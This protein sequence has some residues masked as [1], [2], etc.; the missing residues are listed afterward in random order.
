MMSAT[1]NSTGYG[2]LTGSSGGRWNNLLFNGDERKYETWEVKIMGYMKLKKLKETIGP[3]TTDA[4]NDEKNE[5]AFAELI[6]FLDDRS[7]S[8]VMRD[9]RDNGREALKILRSHYRGKGKQRI[10]CLYTELTTLVKSSTEN[11]T[12]YLL[13]AEKSSSALLNAGETISDGLLVSMVLKGLPPQFKSFV[14]VVTQSDKTWTFKDL[15]ASLRDYED[16][17]KTRV[18]DRSS[19]SVMRT[20]LGGASTAGGGSVGGSGESNSYI[21]FSCN[22]QGHRSFEC[23]TKQT[24][25]RKKWCNICKTNKHDFQ[26]CRKNKQNKGYNSQNQAKQVNEEFHTFNFKVSDGYSNKHGKTSSFLVDSGCSSHIVVDDGAFVECDPNFVPDKHFVELADGRKYNNIALM[27]GTVKI[28]LTDSSGNVHAALLHNCLYIPSFPENI[29]SIKAATK[30]G[31]SIIFTPECSELVTQDGVVFEIH[32][33][34]KL[35]Y[36]CEVTFVSRVLDLKTWHELLGHCNKNDILK[37][38]NIVDGMKIND[39]N[40]KTELICEPCILGKQTKTTD[41]KQT[42]RATRPL[43]FVCSDVC[44]PITPVAIDGFQYVVTFVDTYS[45]F[46]FPYFCKVKSDV[47]K[48]LEKFL[49]DV[50]PV[51]KVK[52]LHDISDVDVK[53]LRSDNGGEYMG[54]EFKQVLVK[55]GIKHEQS[56]PY[57]PHQNGI[58]ERQW[59]TL[60]STVRCLLIGSGLPSKLWTYALMASAYI[61]NRCFQQRIKQTAYFLLTGKKPDFSNLHVFGSVCYSIEQNKKKLDPRSKRGIFVGWDKESPAFL[62]YHADTGRVQRCRCVK[63]TEQLK[64]PVDNSNVPD[65]QNVAIEN[66]EQKHFNFDGDDD[67]PGN[68]FEDVPPVIN[69]VLPEDV[70]LPDDDDIDDILNEVAVDAA[71]DQDE[72]PA[73]IDDIL[74]EVAVGQVPAEVPAEIESQLG[75]S[76]H[77]DGNRRYPARERHGPSHL[78]DYEM[79]VDDV[80]DICKVVNFIPNSHNDAMRSGDADSWKAAMDDEIDSLKHNDTYKLV[81]LPEGKKVIGG[82]WVYAIKDSPSGQLYKA[83][84]VAKGFSQIPGQ[85][86]FE[87]YSPTAKMTSVRSLMQVSAEMD[88]TVHQMDVKT[89][90]LHAPIDCEIYVKQPE[91]FVDPNNKNGVWKLKKSLYGLKQSGRNWNSLLHDFFVNNSFIQSKVDPCVSFHRPAKSF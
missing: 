10:I 44:G 62:V 73:D 22:K 1:T 30:S 83:R 13:R 69:H 21:C 5:E 48:C 43:E 9:A 72:V 14:A 82:R 76:S 38:E 7:L 70:P 18:Q 90:Y 2:P 19:S 45:G 81:Q 49:A 55:N 27:K 79:N 77:C 37:L 40:N 20:S 57:S 4:P 84:Y 36:L 52:S 26:K 35:Y 75:A 63:F 23:P 33:Q 89:A 60:F 91:G 34:G 12:D 31:A 47:T 56:A 58:A 39:K 65:D 59:R 15:K 46:I 78:N 51:G 85:N 54:N 11:V 42:S 86:V 8:L 87:T 24:P 88:L 41:K 53:Q 28:C 71:V 50:S 64:K 16:I 29:F 66:F 61:R 80:V 74:N 32:N 6:Q 3:D 17:E 67:F 25:P 68:K